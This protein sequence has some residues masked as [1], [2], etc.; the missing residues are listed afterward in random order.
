MLR[1]FLTVVLPLI[2]PLALYLGW[3]MTLGAAQ[4]GGGSISW[5]TVPW[6]WLAVAGVGLL[7]I[8]LVVVTVGF[9]APEQGVYVPP[10]LEDGRVVPGHIV[11][12]GR[13]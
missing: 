12:S 3:V 4:E 13:R 5:T 8:V 11:P 2:L 6:L 7:A 9:G 1:V 10:H